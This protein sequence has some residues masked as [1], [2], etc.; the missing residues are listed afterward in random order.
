[1]NKQ[2]LC[3]FA[4]ASLLSPA[5][6]A[7]DLLPQ[8]VFVDGGAASHDTDSVTVG[9]QWPWS[10]HSSF[11][12]GEATALTEVYLSRWSARNMSGRESFTQV[13]VVPLL[14]LRPDHGGSDW[15]LDLGIG[16]SV[17]DRLYTTNRK[18]F[19]TRFNFFDVAGL[20]RSFGAERKQE[21]SL[22]VAHVS[23][24]DIRKPNP[25]ETFLQLR[26]GVSF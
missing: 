3:G 11:V 1:M 13:G 22:R 15:F 12:R 16:L 5:S 6:H 14:R 20:G 9:A 19:S 8:R 25:G 24:A 26:Y 23:N 4:A 10:W 2:W 17:M 21:I 7:A 18:Q